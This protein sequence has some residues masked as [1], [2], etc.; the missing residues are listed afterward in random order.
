MCFCVSFYNKNKFRKKM[1]KSREKTEKSGCFVLKTAILAPFGNIFC[2]KA[3][4][5]FLAWT[6]FITQTHIVNAKIHTY[7]H[8]H[9]HTH[10]FLEKYFCTNTLTSI[11][12]IGIKETLESFLRKNYIFLYVKTWKNKKNLS[13]IFTLFVLFCESK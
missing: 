3:N 5:W 11:T 6:V 8:T 12:V 13:E 7:T 9:T 2:Y 4:D 1:D 10:T